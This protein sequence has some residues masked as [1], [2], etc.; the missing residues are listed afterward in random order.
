MQHKLLDNTQASP[1]VGLEL[2]RI[3]HNVAIDKGDDVHSYH[4]LQVVVAQKLAE[5]VGIDAT[6]MPSIDTFDIFGGLDDIVDWLDEQDENLLMTAHA[7]SLLALGLFNNGTIAQLQGESLREDGEGNEAV[8]DVCGI[9][10]F[11]GFLK[12][13]PE[14]E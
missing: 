6:D 4:H 3:A 11:Y 10:R 1:E 12:T 9:L 8:P 14:T 7:A 2:A 13:Y 5:L